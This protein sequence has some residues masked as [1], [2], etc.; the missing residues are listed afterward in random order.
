VLAA[1]LAP[2]RMVAQTD[3]HAVSASVSSRSSSA[4]PIRVNTTPV[5]AA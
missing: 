2:V 1:V 3:S 4:W 5:P